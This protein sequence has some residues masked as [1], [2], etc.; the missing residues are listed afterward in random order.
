MTGMRVQDYI[1]DNTMAALESFIRNVEALPADKLDWKPEPTSRSALSMLAEIGS[2]GV[3]LMQTMRTMQA[4]A[5]DSE[6]VKRAQEVRAQ[7]NTLDRARDAARSR[8]QE[9]CE[10][11]RS[12]DDSSLAQMVDMPWAE[13]MRWSIADVAGF[14]HWNLVWHTGQVAYIQS[15]LGDVEMH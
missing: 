3:L 12:L 13:G 10:V 8:T 15:L 4:P 9:Y 2:T 14:H 5:M 1:A 7:L 11:V 6:A